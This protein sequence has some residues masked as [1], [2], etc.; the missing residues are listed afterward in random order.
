MRSSPPPWLD[1]QQLRSSEATDACLRSHTQILVIGLGHS[2]SLLIYLF[3]GLFFFFFLQLHLQHTE[4]P[5]LGFESELQPL[6]YTIATATL[7]PSGIAAYLC[8]SLWQRWILNPL[9]EARDE[10]CILMD[11]MSGS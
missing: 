1:M 4:V 11:T 9:S 2:A 5:R 7:G 10:I 8:C 6:A 3:I